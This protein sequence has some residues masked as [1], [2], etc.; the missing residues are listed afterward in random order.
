V[1]EK[2]KQGPIS[3]GGEVIKVSYK[4]SRTKADAKYRKWGALFRM[5]KDKKT[6]EGE[7]KPRRPKK[8]LARGNG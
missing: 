2:K 8:P 1:V 7:K 6:Q 3:T 5:W 4:G